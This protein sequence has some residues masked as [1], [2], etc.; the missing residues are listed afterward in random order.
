MAAGGFNLSSLTNS[1][2]ETTIAAGLSVGLIVPFRELFRGRYRLLNTKVAAS[3]AAYLLH[4]PIVIALQ[5]AISPNL[6]SCPCWGRWRP[7]S[8]GTWPARCRVSGLC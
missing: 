2:W 1:I 7:L 3:F 8:L 6:S 4:P 5:A